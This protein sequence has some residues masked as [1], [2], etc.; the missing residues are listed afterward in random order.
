[1]KICFKC[2]IKKPYSEFYK[3]KQMADGYLNKCKECAKKDTKKRQEELS[4]DP[5]WLEKERE[6]QREKYVRLN[7]KDKQKVWDAE[8]EWKN[9]S[10]YKNLSRKFKMP[11]GIERHHW[12][13]NEKFLEDFFALKREDHRYI[14]KFLILDIEKRIFLTL[15]GEP[16]DTKEKHK[17]YIDKLLSNE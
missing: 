11:K 2:K 16:L 14:H 9:T 13:Y 5:E 15:D 6:R 1:M 12:N 17:T 8:K 3:H 10:A 4:K 7:Y